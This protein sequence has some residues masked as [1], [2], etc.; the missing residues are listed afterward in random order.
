MLDEDSHVLL[1]DFGLSLMDD[2]VLKDKKFRA[3][4]FCGTPEFMAPEVLLSIPY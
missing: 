1:A 4:I 2:R 3:D